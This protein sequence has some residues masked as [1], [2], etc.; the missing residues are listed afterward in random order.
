MST[1]RFR[2]C[3]PIVVAAFGALSLVSTA[4]LAQTATPE[5]AVD[6]G[7][8]MFRESCAACHG[9]NGKG[10][11]PASDAMKRRPTNLTTLARQQGGFRASELEASIKG[12]SQVVA[13]GSPG[14]MVWG[15]LFLAD[16]NGN[17]AKADA[18]ISDLVAFIESIQ[19]K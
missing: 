19:G 11:G 8:A 13:H 5:R 15:A 4:T 9:A 14:M 10:D 18:R 12:T 16:A 1:R 17:Q 3:A 7:K 6:R 2:V